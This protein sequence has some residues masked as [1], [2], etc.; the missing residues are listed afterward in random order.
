MLLGI[1]VV[2]D[3]PRKAARPACAC[4]SARAGGARRRGHRLDRAAGRWPPSAWAGRRCS[5]RSACRSSS[6]TSDRHLSRHAKSPGLLGL[7]DRRWPWWWRRST[8]ELIFRAGLFRYCARG[9]RAGPRCCC[10]PCFSPRLHAESR[11][12]S[13]RWSRWGSSFP[14]PTSAPGSI[15]VPDDR[16]RALQPAHH[17]PGLRRRQRL[18]PCSLCPPPIRDSVAALGE[19]RLIAA[20]RRWLGSASPRGAVR[21]RRRLRRAA[22]RAAAPA[23]HRRSR[24]LWPALRRHRAAA[25]R[26]ARSSSS[27]TSATSRRWAAGPP[28][29]CSRS[30]SMRRTSVAWLRSI[31]TAASP[32]A[33][34]VTVSRSSAATSPRPTGVLAASLTLLGT[35]TGPR[36]P[37]PHRRPRGRLDLRHRRARRQPAQ[38][39]PLPL[40]APPGRGRLAGAPPGSPRHDGPERRAGEGSCA[41]SPRAVAARRSKPAAHP[42]APG[43]ACAAALTD[44]EDYELLFALAKARRPR[45]PSRRLWRRAFPAHPL[46]CIGRFDAQTGKIRRRARPGR[47]TMATSICA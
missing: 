30:R 1:A 45:T 28:R 10:P 25:R 23:D 21:H 38:R 18:S 15:A 42:A 8:E 40:H 24:D 5:A 46:T 17:L 3:L 47:A 12:A 4:R 2:Q 11:R 7:H 19:E 16:A 34:A 29:P 37:H 41:R 9:C 20:I 31:S 36:V 14:S 6:R 32:P 22:R 35:A 33:P 39:P 44:G 27:A 13:P 26:R 43:C